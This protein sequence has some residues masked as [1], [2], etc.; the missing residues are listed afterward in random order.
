MTPQ[1]DENIAWDLV[2]KVPPGSFRDAR[3]RRVHHH[4]H[5]DVWLQ[6]DPSG[7]WNVSDTPTEAASGV[8]GLSIPLLLQSRLVVGQVGQSLDG[9]IA[10]ATGRSHYITGPEDIRRLHRVRA[11]V[12]AVVVGARTVTSDDPR[13][14]V[15]EV[16]GENPV[17]VVL[18]PAGRLA[19]SHKVFSDGAGRTV[20]VRARKSALDDAETV[21]DPNV[22]WLPVSDEGRFAPAS[23]LAGLGSL[24]LHRVLVEGGAMTVSG[25]L[26]AGVLDR[27][28]VT[29]A[30]ILIGSGPQSLELD[31][32]DGL[33]EALRPRVHRFR[34]GDDMLFDLDFS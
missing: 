26:R 28:Q 14:T 21:D 15:R 19:S 1:I 12:D 6:V 7:A 17:R 25:F 18:D 34:L 13:L 10:T 8:L 23:I 9:R 16:P 24:G 3:P 2:R 31:P 32:I 20:R 30:P 11:L 29:V 5:P 33:S 27:L 22:L 4:S